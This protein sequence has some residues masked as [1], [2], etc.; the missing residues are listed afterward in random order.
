MEPIAE[1]LAFIPQTRQH[2]FP[3]YR[4]ELLVLFGGSAATG[5]DV[6]AVAYERDPSRLERLNRVLSPGAQ[7]PLPFRPSFAL[8]PH[9]TSIAHR[10]VLDVPPP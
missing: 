5:I 1:L 2:L 9:I 3:D 8:P 10:E 4:H 7:I 6:L